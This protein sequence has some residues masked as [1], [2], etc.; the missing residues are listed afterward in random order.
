MDSLPQNHEGSLWYVVLISNG[1]LTEKADFEDLFTDTE[2]VRIGPTNLH[3]K[4]S[5]NA[6]V[7]CPQAIVCKI[8]V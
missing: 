4:P 8:T 3:F 5:G 1:A 7:V 6:G 2:Q